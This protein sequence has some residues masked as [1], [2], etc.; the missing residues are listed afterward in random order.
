MRRFEPSKPQNKK[1]KKLS[2]KACASNKLELNPAPLAAAA[3]SFP[4]S[5]RVLVSSDSLAL[6]VLTQLERL[7]P[8]S[9]AGY[10][11]ENRRSSDASTSRRSGG[12]RRVCKGLGTEGGEGAGFGHLNGR[13]AQ[14]I[15]G[16]GIYLGVVDSI[17]HRN[18]ILGFQT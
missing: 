4:N 15:I 17:T 12:R 3:P 1:N 16:V 14:P 9:S 11:G 5:V 18:V 10:R 2:L 13:Y 7:I 6:L 8:Q